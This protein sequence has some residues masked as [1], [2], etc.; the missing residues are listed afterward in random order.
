MSLWYNYGV[1]TIKGIKWGFEGFND[2]KKWINLTPK[3]ITDIHNQGGSILGTS[4]GGYDAGKII[5]TLVSNKIDILYSIGGDGTHRAMYALNNEIL[6]RNLKIILAGI[7]KTIDNDIPLIDRSFGFESAI[8]KAVKAISSAN[9]EANC[10]PNG[11]GLVKL[12]GRSCGF[13]ALMSTQANRDVNICLIPEAKFNLYGEKGLLSYIF[14]RLR[15]K[16][17]CVIVVAEGAGIK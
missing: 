7:P 12:F 1:K 8:E 17:H 4:R 11:I 16:G 3:L 13:I 10:V 6:K 14:K 5:D 15:L 2:N 9:V